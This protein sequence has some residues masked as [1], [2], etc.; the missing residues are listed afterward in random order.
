MK[1]LIVLLISSLVLVSL[2]FATQVFAV[3]ATL[4][5]IGPTTLPPTNNTTNNVVNNTPGGGG[6]N[7]PTNNVPTNNRPGGGNQPNVV[8]NAISPEGPTGGFWQQFLDILR[9]VFVGPEFAG[10]R[11]IAG[12]VIAPLLALLGLLNLFLAIP[13]LSWWPILLK[14]FLFPFQLFSL[15]K[16][17]YWGVVYDVLSQQPV[18]LAIVR[19]FHRNDNEKV[20]LQG[21]YV[22]DSTGRYSFDIDQKGVYFLRVQKAKYIFPSALLKGAHK[23][24]I[25]D[26]LYYG[27]DIAIKEDDAISLNIPLD[28]E[29]QVRRPLKL[30]LRKY[31][32]I[33]WHDFVAYS[34]IA[35][36]FVVFIFVRTQI[37]FWMFVIQIILFI[38]YL[39]FAKPRKVRPWGTVYEGPT[40][41]G[42]AHS[43]VRIFNVKYNR[44]LET[45][46]ADRLGRYSFL[47]G[48]D[49]YRVE[50]IKPGFK[51]PAKKRYH[52]NDY[53]G[54]NI[55]VR[56]PA[57]IKFN[58]PLEPRK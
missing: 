49:I 50:A 34:G 52:I 27:K 17:Q 19:L 54:K 39:Y 8:N 15:G 7:V 28:P 40:N 24:G 48:K 2:V 3:D 20:T 9:A 56:K 41:K 47:V 53:L 33:I 21:T 16:R 25:Y 5:I 44:V 55:R 6:N 46:V 1:K 43:V 30:I 58:I 35:L 42:L 31:W 32:R 51:F 13:L 26:N 12:S 11:G 14:W 37:S 36:N 10:A 22:T 18:D 4:N 45:R 29:E 57:D 38:I 23:D